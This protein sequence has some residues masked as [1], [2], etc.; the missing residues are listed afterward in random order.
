[1]VH[2]IH[3]FRNQPQF[4]MFK[5]FN[6]FFA[7]NQFYWRSSGSFSFFSGIGGKGAGCD[8][9]PF[10][11]TPIH[12][13]TKIPDFLR[14]NAAAPFFALEYDAEAHQRV[15]LKNP[16]TIDSTIPGSASDFNFFKSRFAQE[17]LANSF[18]TFGGKIAE[19]KQQ[20]VSILQRGRLGHRVFG[21]GGPRFR[22]SA[23][24][25]VQLDPF[26]KKRMRSLIRKLASPP[27][28]S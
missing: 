17:P 8:E 26:Q 19:H 20:I 1:M 7:I 9:D 10:F 14:R 18:K 15:D 27:H 3:N 28:W 12:G 2:A 24:F 13:T 4:E 25:C 11:C 5:H 21:L 6:E 16:Y 23:L 22:L